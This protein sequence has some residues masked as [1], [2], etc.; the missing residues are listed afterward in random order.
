[1]LGDEASGNYF[2]KKIINYYFNGLFDESLKLKFEKNYEN[3]LMEIKRNIYDHRA[4]VYLSK[5]FPFVS[6]NKSHQIIKNL[7]LDTLDDFFELHV[8]CFK[9]YNPEEINF[10][11]SVSFFL[12]E[13]IELICK[14]HE[15]KL[16]KVVKNPI[17]RLLKYHTSDKF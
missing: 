15:L 4:N 16:G 12:K 1:M 7:I 8:N 13:E 11:G 5:F 14:K 10:I 3:D 2:G 17:E 9:K 6:N